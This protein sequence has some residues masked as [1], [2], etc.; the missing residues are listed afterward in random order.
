[1]VEKPCLRVCRRLYYGSQTRSVIV[2][3]TVTSA[4]W[5]WKEP[6]GQ[7]LCWALSTFPL[8][9]KKSAFWGSVPGHVALGS[10][11]DQQSCKDRF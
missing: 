3:V 2:N 9:P 5:G 8:G 10:V 4:W 6:V 11:R 1:M 7:G